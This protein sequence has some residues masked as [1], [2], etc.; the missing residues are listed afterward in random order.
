MYQLKIIK[1][2]TKTKKQKAKTDLTSLEG[3]L[4]IGHISSM[5]RTSDSLS[6][7]VFKKERK[8]K[9]RN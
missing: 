9:E 8:E 5:C 6:R 1:E 4:V 7:N 3:G 2:A